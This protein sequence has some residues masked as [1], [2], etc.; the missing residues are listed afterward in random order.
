MDLIM[1]NVNRKKQGI[2]DQGSVGDF[3]IKGV[4][5]NLIEPFSKATRIVKA[6]IILA[7]FSWGLFY[8]W[9]VSGWGY[10]TSTTSPFQNFLMLLGAKSSDAEVLQWIMT[11]FLFPIS[12][13]ARFAIGSLA[14]STIFKISDLIRGIFRSI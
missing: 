11:A 3:N 8:S 4:D 7:F 14:M 12:W 1:S 6:V 2:D 9:D 10:S 5:D 13:L